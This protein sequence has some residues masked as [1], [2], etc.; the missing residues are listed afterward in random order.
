MFC[1]T[2]RNPW[3]SLSWSTIPK[4][5]SLDSRQLESL[6]EV[7]QHLLLCARSVHK[8]SCTSVLHIGL[9]L[10][11]HNVWGSLR[12]MGCSACTTPIKQYVHAKQWWYMQESV[13]PIPTSQTWQDKLRCESKQLPLCLHCAVAIISVSVMRSHAQNMRD[14]ATALHMS[15]TAGV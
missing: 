7:R 8:R 14:T 9:C 6:A 10:C 15:V 1:A 12:T 11:I 5:R 2:C 3:S 13:N 4:H